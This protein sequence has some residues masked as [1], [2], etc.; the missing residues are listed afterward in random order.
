MPRDAGD[1]GAII[2]DS[3]VRQARQI[4]AT[5]RASLLDQQKG[6]DPATLVNGQWVNGVW[7]AKPPLG[8][9]HLDGSP[10]LR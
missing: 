3:A 6:G 5:G 2:I 1:V 10:G 8:V 4:A 7:I 9:I